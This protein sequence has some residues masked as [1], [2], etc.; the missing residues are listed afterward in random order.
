MVEL[1]AVLLPLFL[2]AP[3]I[4]LD[5]TEPMTVWA[6]ILNI[7][8]PL[9]VYAVLMSIWRRAAVTA[10]CLFPIMVF[11]GFQIVL[12]YLYGGSIIGVDMFLNV[13]TTNISEVNELLGNLI[14]AIGIIALL[15]IPALI[16]AI[17]A[18]C[19]RKKLR[20]HFIYPF[21]R[22]SFS[23][24]G[25]SIILTAATL[26]F[27][28]GYSFRKYLFPVNVIDN[29]CRAV[30]RT[31]KVSHYPVTS[32]G[33][34]FEAKSKRDPSLNEIYVLMIGETSRAENWQLG[35]YGRQTN[36]RLMRNNR[37]IY[38]PN[39]FTESNTTHKSVPMIM[40]DLT[41][42]DFDSIN[43]RKSI[44]TAFKEAGFHT[45]FFS[46]QRRNRSYTEFFSNE[47]D[48]TVYITDN[49]D[50]VP[51]DGELVG[52]LKKQIADTT[53]TKQLIV[54]HTYGSHF[55]YRDRY[56]DSFSH[57]TPDNITDANRGHRQQLVNAFDNTIRYVDHCVAEAIDAVDSMNVA[58]ALIYMPDHGEDIFDDSRN[59]FLHA[60]P[61]PTYYQLHV[62]LI[63]WLSPELEQ[64]VPLKNENLKNN[65]ETTVSISSDVF[66]T[67]L[68]LSG[69][70]TK[71]YDKT[72]SLSSE[73]FRKREPR[74]L[75]DRNESIPVSKSGLTEEE[76]S[77]I[78]NNHKFLRLEIKSFPKIFIYH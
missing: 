4:A 45:S 33:Y 15:Y 26:I 3:N 22:L 68:D 59:R 7:I 42:D 6:K 34:K 20:S 24:L 63:V 55:N 9:S 64:L 44:I 30:D 58:G 57:F 52:L 28:K 19:R 27:D 53:K 12:L 37:I 2:I 13:V 43:Y 70:T 38:F 74:Y 73:K 50:G 46:S 62:P 5:I 16:A 54:L 1:I 47:A 51:F 32:A 29:L 40:S 11:A 56:P 39:A 76:I 18:L 49:A 71:E 41:A 23:L 17:V 75:T 78:K 77:R 69:M 61:I 48:T 21:R 66:H 60:S 25:L 14:V 8:I 31:K 72:R 35:G 67:L 10:L 36:P 65:R